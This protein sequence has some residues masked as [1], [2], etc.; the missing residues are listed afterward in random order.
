MNYDL[1][2]EILL[3]QHKNRFEQ[4]SH[5]G[6]YREAEGSRRADELAA[7]GEPKLEWQ[8]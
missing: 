6:V 8:M 4:E 3:K 5:Q 1:I 7:E 2:A